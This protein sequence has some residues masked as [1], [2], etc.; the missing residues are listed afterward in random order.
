MPLLNKDIESYCEDCHKTAQDKGW[1]EKDPPTVLESLCLITSEISEAVEVYRKSGPSCL[2]EKS[3]YGDQFQNKVK[4]F[5]SELADIAIRLFDFCG[6][7]GIDLQYEIDAKILY[8]RT[9]EY[10]HGGKFK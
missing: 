6:Y 5:G 8:N 7:H 1:Y 4:T 2:N 3:D 9:R 10:R